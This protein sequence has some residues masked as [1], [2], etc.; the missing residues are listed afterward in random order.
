MRDVIR[1]SSSL[2]LLLLAA[3]LLPPASSKPKKDWGAPQT[4]ACTTDAIGGPTFYKDGGYDWPFLNASAGFDSFIPPDSFDPAASPLKD[5]LAVIQYPRTIS[6]Q[7]M[8]VNVNY[9]RGFKHVVH[10]FSGGDMPEGM[11]VTGEGVE[12]QEIVYDICKQPYWR[13]SL[14]RIQK[15]KGIT[16]DTHRGSEMCYVCI[17]NMI[18]QR[19]DL[20]KYRG[21]LYFHF[22]FYVDIYSPYWATLDY[23]RF[24][25]LRP[26]VV[27]KHTK[28][29]A[30]GKGVLMV[31]QRYVNMT[32]PGC[33]TPKNV[34]VGP[35]IAA[36]GLVTAAKVKHDTVCGV[37]SPRALQPE[38]KH[39]KVVSFGW[40]DMFYVPREVFQDFA[41]LSEMFAHADTFHEVAIATMMDMLEHKVGGR[42]AEVLKCG[43]CCCCSKHWGR[44]AGYD[45]FKNGVPCGHPVDLRQEKWQEAIKEMLRGPDRTRLLAVLNSKSTPVPV[46]V[47]PGLV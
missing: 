22:D 16:V 40:A 29:K 33:G 15:A 21:I 31:P 41:E 28:N 37:G 3:L 34:P 30:R 38:C 13:A 6:Y 25:T 14:M 4:G 2:L 10:L 7:R 47:R 11:N 43:G 8:P 18:R 24:W 17:A 45:D 12:G 20:S 39:P 19:D 36:S 27:N 1:S 42:A 46:P 44:F 9:I 23:S 32:V 5:V 26:G 35:H